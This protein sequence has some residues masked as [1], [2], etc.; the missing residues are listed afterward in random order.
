M[1]AATTTTDEGTAIRAGAP[2]VGGA[3]D[4]WADL[5]TGQRSLTVALLLVMVA[6]ALVGELFAPDVA[7]WAVAVDVAVGLVG[8]VAL[9]VLV[10]RHT[11][12]STLVAIVA[13][14]LTPAATPLAATCTLWVARRRPLRLSVPVAASG[15]AALVLLRAWRPAA[16]LGTGGWAALGVASYAAVVGWGA[17]RRAYVGLVASMAERARRA[18]REQAA[19]VRAAQQAE[20]DRMARE[21]HDVL[22]HRLTLLTTYAGALE[23]RDDTPPDQLRE[24]IGIIRDSAHRALAELREVIGVLRRD[25]EPDA[26]DE[27]RPVPGIDD[28]PRLL[29]DCRRVGMDVELVGTPADGTVPEQVGRAVH[30]VVQ[31]ALTNVRKHASG[32]AARVEVAGRAGDGVVVVVVNEPPPTGAAAGVPPG[33]GTGLVG[34][35]ERVE[36]AG[37]HVRHGPTAEGGYRVQAELPWPAS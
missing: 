7:A 5:T 28:L 22:A 6:G 29:D 23:Y 34:L 2:M 14:A 26:V 10:V 12:G 31:E 20:R 15:V 17:W 37:G 24:A 19:R 33:S 3:G 25:V 30:R 8:A 18:E 13:S 11:V 27:H 36:V 35:G 9:P 32:A 21:M 16:G 4:G 1:Q